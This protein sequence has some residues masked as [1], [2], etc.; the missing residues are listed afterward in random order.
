MFDEQVESEVK[1]L[2]GKQ[3]HEE[4]NVTPL[5]QRIFENAQNNS[6][7][8][9]HGFRHDLIVKKFGAALYCLV[10][11]SGFEL[12][13]TNLGSALP[14]ISTV[15]R[16]VT[17]KKVKE[18]KFY[19]KELKNHLEEWKS[20]PYV[21]IHIDD[22]RVK[23]LIEYDSVNDKF[24]GFCFKDAIPDLEMFRF[25]TFDEIKDAFKNN[26]KAK[27]AH[28][29]VAKSVEVICPSF[30]LCVIGTDSKYDNSV[31]SF[32]WNYITNHLKEI[33]V[34]VV[35]NGADGAGPFLKAMLAESKLFSV[36]DTLLESWS[37]FYMP[38]FSMDTLYAQ[39]HIHLLAKLRSRL[40]KPSNLIVLGNETACRAHVQQV[41]ETFP[42]EKHNLTQR[43]IDN[44][45]K[46]NYSSIP[47]LVSDDVKDC[48]E[49]LNQSS[50]NTGTIM[51]L[52]IMRQILNAIFDKSLSQLER[53]ALMWR[54]AF[55]CRIWRK[56][57]CLNGY[58]EKDHF[59]TANVYLCIEINAHMILCLVINVMNG[60][61]P[62]ECLRVWTTGSQ[63][64]EQTF[65]L[66]RSMS[67][68]FSTMVNFTLKGILE[69]INK[70]N[71][72][73]SIECTE[74]IVFP[75]VKRR[76]LQLNEESDKTLH[77]PSSI[78]EIHRCIEESKSDAIED[79]KKCSMILNEYDD[80]ALMMEN[81]STLE[82]IE[83]EDDNADVSDDIPTSAVNTAQ[84]TDDA[85]VKEDLLQIR[86]RKDNHHGMP[87]YSLTTEKGTSIN[88][89]YQPSK[90]VR[91]QGAF[92][93][94]STALYLLQENPVLSSDRLIRVRAGPDT[95]SETEL[96]EVK[97]TVTSGDLCVFRRIDDNDKILIGRIVQFSYLTG[98]KR[99]QE[100]SGMYVDLKKD[101]KSIG[102]FA[103]WF[104]VSEFENNDVHFSPLMNI[105]TQGYI[106]ME[107]YVCTIPECNISMTQTGFKLSSTMRILDI[108]NWKDMLTNLSE[109]QV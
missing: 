80:S 57:L 76:L 37:F 90:F 51:Y 4:I 16:L 38:S 14:S 18:G 5:L 55:F 15:Q 96:A 75:R 95:I 53:I 27:Y 84:C 24:I 79:A 88:K 33:G 47:I 11:R 21:N 61:L 58:S 74:E 56:W 8:S 6:G 25:Q 10:G 104:A 54:V 7:G 34:T 103:N 81:I 46:Q 52:K 30:I 70:L 1:N 41:F 65:R 106:S 89:S 92:I 63:A 3:N 68:T 73:A 39:D 32:R 109:F 105:F 28:C 43:C 13:Q 77:I 36:S 69:R 85:L 12:L 101:H 42:K 108:E 45:D 22:T 72:V 62:K 99:Q 93:R 78:D 86:L 67:G 91:Y 94:K 20:P 2:C 31:V 44:K 59:L 50:Q 87:T 98:N 23:A 82:I 9:K 107:K 64:C 49:Q 26:T 19:F 17:T 97:S 60:K 71:Y 35:C 100:Y 83:S 29:I 66:L 48:L 102:A 40:L